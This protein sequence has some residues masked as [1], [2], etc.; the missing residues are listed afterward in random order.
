MSMLWL[1]P[2][3]AR[4]HPLSGGG[5]DGQQFPPFVRG[6]AGGCVAGA[7]PT[8]SPGELVYAVAEVF[9]LQNEN[10]KLQIDDGARDPA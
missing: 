5:T 1:W 9:K 10:C 8:G 7:G 6:G 4:V 3:W 2:V